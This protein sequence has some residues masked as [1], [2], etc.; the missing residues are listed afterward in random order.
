MARTKFK[1]LAKVK[2]LPNVFSL[3]NPDV[4]DSLKN[5]F[6]FKNIFTIEIG[7]GH[8]DYTIELAQK[9]PRKKFYWNRRK[10]CKDI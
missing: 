5:Y 4:T 7:C 10:R 6:R 8:G 1:R 3:Q 2:E 9:Y